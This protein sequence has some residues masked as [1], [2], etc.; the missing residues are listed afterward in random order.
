MDKTSLIHQNLNR[1]YSCKLWVFVLYLQ[2]KIKNKKRD[3]FGL[4]ELK[5]WAEH[6]IVFKIQDRFNFFFVNK[7]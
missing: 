1:W 3:S 2:K 6:Q 5:K 7:I 4:L